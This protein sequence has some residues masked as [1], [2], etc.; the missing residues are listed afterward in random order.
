[1]SIID[2]I[3]SKLPL[4]PPFEEGEKLKCINERNHHM[5]ITPFNLKKDNTYIVSR[6][7]YNTTEIILPNKKSEY[8]KII[9]EISY[10]NRQQPVNNDDSL[11]HELKKCT[12]KIY[13]P[14]ISITNNKNEY[15][16]T[17]VLVTD[18]YIKEVKKLYF[19]SATY[20]LDDYFIVTRL[21]RNKIFKELLNTK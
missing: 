3:K 21:K 19:R 8:K 12:T 10:I 17:F 14:Y 13:L 1:M 5:E 6:I 4:S 15:I 20:F 7:F 16:Y 18:D 11:F 9:S 2:K